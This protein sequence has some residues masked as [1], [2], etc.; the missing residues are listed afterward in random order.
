MNY[1]Q[2]IRLLWGFLLAATVFCSNAVAQDASKP[3]PS[4]EAKAPHIHVVYFG[5]NDCPPCVAFRGA[6]FPKLEKSPAF[7]KLQ[8]TFV[9]KTV[10]SPIPSSFFLPAHV[11]PHR[12]KLF[13]AT[14]GRGGSAQ[15]VI[16]VDGEV[17]D[18]FHGS[19]DAAFYTQMVASVL[20]A[21]IAYPGERC[22]K[23]D[24]SRSCVKKA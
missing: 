7:A 5:G 9:T 8:W 11:K 4:S 22:L 23:R 6:E 12:D 1:S 18:V 10:G 21:K 2:P 17:F 3:S 24:A 20:D 15:V 16:L 14:G 19:G 13:E